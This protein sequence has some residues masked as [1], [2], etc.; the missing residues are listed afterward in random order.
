MLLVE[1]TKYKV[2]LFE[3]GFIAPQLL[4]EEFVEASFV[5]LDITSD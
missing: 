4:L 2:C 1:I 3:A 5:L